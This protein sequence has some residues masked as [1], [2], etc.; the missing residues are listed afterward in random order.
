MQFLTRKTDSTL[1]LYNSGVTTRGKSG[2]VDPGCATAYQ[3]IFHDD[4]SRVT[5]ATLKWID[6]R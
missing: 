6:T 1:T 3:E 4:D 2:T 5:F